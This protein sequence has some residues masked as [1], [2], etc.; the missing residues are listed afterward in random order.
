MA[1]SLLEELKKHNKVSFELDLGF[2]FYEFQSS[3][4]KTFHVAN[5][6]E[7][8]VNF[9]FTEEELYLFNVFF[10]ETLE[11]GTKSF[12]TDLNIGYGEREYD[13][14]EMPNISH[15]QAYNYNVSLKLL[16][17]DNVADINCVYANNCLNNLL[18]NLRGINT[19]ITSKTQ[20]PAWKKDGA[21]CLINLLNM[22]E[23]DINDY[24]KQKIL[25]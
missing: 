23:E 22:I 6:L 3:Y 19:V 16:Q 24:S 11:Y 14:T 12:S 21:L 5:Y 4:K 7:F 15:L 1:I 13:I 2:S 25:I 9:I 17:K 20:P 10:N 8:S 18:N